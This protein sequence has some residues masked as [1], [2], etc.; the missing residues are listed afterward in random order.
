MQSGVKHL[1]QISLVVLVSNFLIEP[2]PSWFLTL[3]LHRVLSLHPDEPG[4]QHKLNMWIYLKRYFINWIH[5]GHLVCLHILTVF[6]LSK[7]RSA[8]QDVNISV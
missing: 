4:F 2:Q 8:C 3:H 1:P 5:T 6:S 7:A